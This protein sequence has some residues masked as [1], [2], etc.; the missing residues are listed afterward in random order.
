[1]K[2]VEHIRELVSSYANVSADTINDNTRLVG[3]LGIDSFELIN[4]LAEIEEQLGFE[5]DEREVWNLQ[6]FGDIKDYI[7]RVYDVDRGAGA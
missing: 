1:M 7:V 4:L 3:D 5:L 6:K 2:M